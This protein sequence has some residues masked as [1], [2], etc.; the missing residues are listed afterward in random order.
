MKNLDGLA[1]PPRLSPEP[2]NGLSMAWV[3]IPLAGAKLRAGREGNR[4]E[5]HDQLVE[6][7]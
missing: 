1:H 7:E 2:F 6:L 3:V 5:G 4:M